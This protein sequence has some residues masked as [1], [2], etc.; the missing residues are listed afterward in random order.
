MGRVLQHQN[1]SSFYV[2]LLQVSTNKVSFW[3]GAFISIQPFSSFSYYMKSI[4]NT[5]EI[6]EIYTKY[7]RSNVKIFTGIHY[8]HTIL[9]IYIKILLKTEVSRRFS[10]FHFFYVLLMIT[11]NFSKCIQNLF[12]IDKISSSL[13]SSI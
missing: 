5:Y 8:I 2:H 1:E 4:H 10:F 9:C 3:L 6:C 13:T 11:N 12:E 7:P